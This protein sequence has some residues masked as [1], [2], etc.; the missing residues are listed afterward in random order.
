MALLVGFALETTDAV[1]NGRRKL[2]GKGLDLLVVNDATEPGAGFE[3]ETNRVVLLDRGGD[4]E[5]LPLMT[6]HEVA[7]EILDR[8][9][10][11]IAGRR[12]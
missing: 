10:A 3:V 4:A 12:S 5:E 9:A 11:L 6:K 2:E 1:E 7:D 8:V